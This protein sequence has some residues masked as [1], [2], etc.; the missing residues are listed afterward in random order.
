MASFL[1]NEIKVRNASYEEGKYSQTDDN[2][3]IISPNFKKPTSPPSHTI[4]QDQKNITQ[5]NSSYKKTVSGVTDDDLFNYTR[6]MHTGLSATNNLNST[7]KDFNQTHLGKQVGNHIEFT[8][9]NQTQVM[10][11]NVLL[12]RD[13]FLDPNNEN[14]HQV[15]REQMMNMDP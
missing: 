2:L 11:S 9:A 1:L 13:N 14:Y 6:T 10:K 5:N 8:S 3:E 7:N 4:A 12:N 15:Q